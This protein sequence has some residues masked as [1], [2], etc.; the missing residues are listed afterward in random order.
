VFRL[1]LPLTTEPSKPRLCHDER[2]LNLWIRDLPF[3]LDHPLDLPRYLL[4]GLF[5]TTFDDK[6]GYQHVKIHPDSREFFSFAW[7]SYYF[8]FCTLPLAGRQ[9][10]TC[11]IV[12]ALSLPVQRGLWVRL[13]HSILMTG[14]WVSY[15]YLA[16]HSCGH[17]RV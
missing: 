7:K 14:T 2:F 9:A 4:S 10:L 8:S 11:I 16:R 3:K 5:Q 1:V 6:N 12:L 17:S 15:F 13:C